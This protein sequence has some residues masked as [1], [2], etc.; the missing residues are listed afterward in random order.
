MH[1]WHGTVANLWGRHKDFTEFNE[2]FE[3]IIISWMDYQFLSKF[4]M[5]IAK[6]Y[7]TFNEFIV[8]SEYSVLLSIFSIIN[9]NINRH[10]FILVNLSLFHALLIN[11]HVRMWLQKCALIVVNEHNGLTIQPWNV[12]YAVYVI[13]E[14]QYIAALYNRHVLNKYY[15]GISGWCV[16]IH[17]LGEKFSSERNARGGGAP[18][19][20]R[21]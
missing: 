3:K 15:V 2:N 4:W 8:F 5:F 16:D 17:K 9:F 10:I 14:T 18:P 1:P 19:L 20:W 11:D 13:K 21:W 7:S 6:K 12:S